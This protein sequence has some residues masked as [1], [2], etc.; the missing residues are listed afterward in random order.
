MPRNLLPSRHLPSFSTSPAS[1]KYCEFKMT[2]H[3][4]RAGSINDGD[5]DRKRHV[6]SISESVN[7]ST[8]G[9]V[10]LHD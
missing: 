6:D 8:V 10:E 7:S 2:S 5:E 9:E 1:P 3:D 4:L